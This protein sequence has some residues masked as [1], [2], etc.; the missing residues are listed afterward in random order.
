MAIYR[1]LPLLSLLFLTHWAWT[2]GANFQVS[3]DVSK[4]PKAQPY[5]EQ[6][7]PLIE[8]WYPKI[9]DALFGPGYALPFQSVRVIF[10]PVI[11]FG[12]GENRTVVPAYTEQNTVH[13]NFHYLLGMRP[14][15]DYH[16]MLIH[17]LAHV[18]QHYKNADNAGWLVEGIADWVRHKLYEKDIEPRLHLDS[19]GNLEGYERD[20]NKHTF[21][22]QGYLDGYTVTS[23]FLYWL[24]VR[25]DKEIVST[26]NRALR[27]ER[28]SPNLFQARCGAPLET[29]WRQFIA[30][31]RGV[32]PAAAKP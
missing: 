31:S 13:V 29:L 14:P 24:E 10:E 6:L 9:N 25:K 16:A 20:R 22:L 19:S 32:T 21:E 1:R 17:E 18:N 28:Y 11:E 23:A 4:V 5:V 30:E 3:V 2:A 8:E 26:L 27:E 7:K 12:N 15:D